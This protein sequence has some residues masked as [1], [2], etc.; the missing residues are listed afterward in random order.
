MENSPRW[1]VP[2]GEESSPRWRFP[3]GG[4]FPQVKRVPPGG[5]FP[6]VKRVPPGGESSPRW[7]E[8]TTARE[9]RTMDQAP[10]LK[11]IRRRKR[12]QGETAEEISG[13]SRAGD[14]PTVLVVRT[15]GQRLGSSINRR[16]KKK[17]NYAFLND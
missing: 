17:K 13:T 11:D 7:R 9:M 16:K 3:P 6:Q 5:E 2:P 12:W 10:V 15:N 1:R 4:E 14:T 8:L